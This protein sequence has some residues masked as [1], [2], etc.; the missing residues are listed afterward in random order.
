MD[1]DLSGDPERD[2]KFWESFLEA[3]RDQGVRPPYE[4]WYLIRAE[5]YLKRHPDTPPSK[6]RPED[7]TAYL[8]EIG[9]K[10]GLKD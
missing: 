8:E 3:V 4:R 1:M 6:H 5:Q 10:G 9:R 2:A 7:L